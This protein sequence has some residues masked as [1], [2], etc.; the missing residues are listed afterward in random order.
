MSPL[1][2][3]PRPNPNPGIIAL[4]D[5]VVIGVDLGGTN[6]RAGAFDAA[7]KAVGKDYSNSSHAQEGTTAILNA[8]ADTIRQAIQSAG[9]KPAAIGLA[10]PGHADNHAGVVRWA[11]NFGQSVNGVFQM[12][13]DVPIR[14][15]LEDLL[16]LPVVMGND[17]NMAALGEYKYGTG[18]AKARCLVMLTIGTGIGGGVV[19]SPYSVLGKATGPLVLVGGNQGGAELGH[20]IIQYGGLDCNAGTYGSLEAYCQRDAIVARAQHRIRRGRS[21]V[22]SDLTEGQLDR[23]TPRLITEACE[24]GDEVAIEVYE[25]V[26]EMLGVGIGSFINVFAPDVFAIGGQIAKA[27]DWIMK[28]ALRSARN[29]AVQSL[30][31]DCRVTVAQQVEDAGM[32]G[33][34]ALAHE[35]LQWGTP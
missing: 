5:S 26:G 6:V 24:E 21:S 13:R 3:G 23:I 7:G 22:L 19:M 4:V 28:P 12:W 27:G 16:G 10:I 34:A 2:E 31:E 11:P 25:D 30:F 14:K 32:L 17:A 33:A 8:V 18:E 20:V 1:P 9:T 35:Q 15:P 29:T